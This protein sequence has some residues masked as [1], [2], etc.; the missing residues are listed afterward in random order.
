MPDQISLVK[1]VCRYLRYVMIVKQECLE[2]VFFSDGQ[3]RKPV[4][5]VAKFKRSL[6]THLFDLKVASSLFRKEVS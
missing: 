5:S 3:K 4:D 1:T 6:K 2:F